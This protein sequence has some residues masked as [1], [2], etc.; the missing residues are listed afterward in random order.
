M[1]D[2]RFGV[3]VG[4][5]L[6]QDSNPFGNSE[7]KNST[8]VTP[9]GPI[10]YTEFPLSK[11]SWLVCIARHL[12]GH[13]LLPS[14]VNYRGIIYAMKVLGVEAVV[15]ISA[16]GSRRKEIQPGTLVAVNQYID[17]THNR[18]NTFF[19]NGLAAHVSFGRPVCPHVRDLLIAA[20]AILKI[21]VTHKPDAS[22]L[23]VMEGPAFSTE[24]EAQL[25]MAEAGLIGMT[26][27]PEAKLAREAEL[28]YCTLAG[29]T[30]FDA[31]FPERMP[32]TA[33]EVG[34]VFKTLKEQATSVVRTAAELFFAIL[35]YHCNDRIALDHAIMTDPSVITADRIEEQISLL[36]RWAGAHIKK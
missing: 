20:G 15:G 8:V 17:H 27:L 36:K 28:C 18:P 24:A 19:G 7:V 4:S 31:C 14:E 2:R 33:E 9:Y 25:G 5:G 23:M 6:D 3:I 21:P 35:D 12:P 10:D 1:K 22:T 34:Q 30:D 26:S 32:V 29:V 11:N 16:V 13:I